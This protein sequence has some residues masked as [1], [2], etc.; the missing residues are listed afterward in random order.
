M[1]VSWTARHVTLLGT[2]CY[3]CVSPASAAARRPSGTTTPR[4][5][6]PARD[7]TRH[8]S[9]NGLGLLPSGPDPVHRGTSPRFAPRGITIPRR[10]TS[11]P[12]VLRH[13]TPAGP[14]ARQRRTP[15]TGGDGRPRRGG[16]GIR[17]PETLAGQHGFQPCA[18]GR[19]R[20]TLQ[21]E[22]RVRT[23]P[24]SGNAGAAPALPPRRPA[25]ASARDLSAMCRTSRDG[26][27]TDPRVLPRP[28]RRSAPCPTS[29][30][31]TPATASRP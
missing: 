14:R 2:S 17:T 20:R 22:R 21:A 18:I 15:A 23:A 6:D 10:T 4:D 19:T 24:H 3:G 27:P 13:R 25:V 9:E 28:D 7:L 30:S 31:P 12:T 5:P 26:T 16:W 8:P 11:L 29:S 1:V